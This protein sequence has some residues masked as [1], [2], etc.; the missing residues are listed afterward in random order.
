MNFHEKFCCIL[1]GEA[2][3]MNPLSLQLN[4]VLAISTT[5]VVMRM[6]DANRS[7]MGFCVLEVDYGTTSRSDAVRRPRMS[8][9]CR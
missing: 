4:V 2:S 7:G 6:Q 1:C 5:I 9:R 8:V 3:T